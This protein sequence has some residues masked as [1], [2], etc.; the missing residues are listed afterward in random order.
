MSSS[1]FLAFLMMSGPSLESLADS[2]VA[3]RS[4]RVFAGSR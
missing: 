4:L 1:C 3:F 2:I